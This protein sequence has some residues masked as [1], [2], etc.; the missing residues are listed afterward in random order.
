MRHLREQSCC[1]ISHDVCS[2]PVKVKHFSLRLNWQIY[3]FSGNLFNKNGQFSKKSVQINFHYE[4][5]LQLFHLLRV[6][7]IWNWSKAILQNGFQVVKGR[8][9]VKVFFFYCHI[10]PNQP[11]YSL[12]SILRHKYTKIRIWNVFWTT[13]TFPLPSIDLSW[14]QSCHKEK[15]FERHML[16]STPEITSSNKKLERTFTIRN[17]LIVFYQVGFPKFRVNIIILCWIF[18]HF[19]QFTFWSI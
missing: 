17:R 1:R 10:R 7:N 2:Y 5:E 15:D 16:W 4:H 11:R 13:L 8:G 19:H 12:L 18:P 9:K 3:S 6:F 14:G